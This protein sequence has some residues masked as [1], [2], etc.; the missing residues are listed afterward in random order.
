MEKAL[1]PIYP[2]FEFSLPDTWTFSTKSEDLICQDPQVWVESHERVL[3]LNWREDIWEHADD[4]VLSSR[5][6]IQGFLIRFKGSL[7]LWDRIRGEG[8]FGYE[9]H[10]AGPIFGGGF[11]EDS[12]MNFELALK[13]EKITLLTLVSDDLLKAEEVFLRSA[14]SEELRKESSYRLMSATQPLLSNPQ[15]EMGLSM[16]WSNAYF[17]Q[18]K[19]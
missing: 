18:L 5:H 16:D 6:Q 3:P 8:L 13:S 4:K 1:D 2:S 11:K 14:I 10:R 9:E 15:V 17:D 12:S 19:F 7:L